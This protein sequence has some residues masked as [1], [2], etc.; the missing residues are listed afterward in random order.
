LDSSPRDEHCWLSAAS[1][2]THSGIGHG[3]GNQI[4]RLTTAIATS[5][6]DGKR[7]PKTTTENDASERQDRI[8]TTQEEQS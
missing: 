8:A 3:N 1:V 7:R 2:E 5:D 4:V 6:D